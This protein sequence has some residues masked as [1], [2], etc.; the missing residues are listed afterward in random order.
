MKRSA[1]DFY[2]AAPKKEVGE[3]ASIGDKA[4]A[5]E[6][7]L[8]P[9]D[10][11]WCPISR[12]FHHCDDVLAAHIVP[13]RVGPS[14]LGYIFEPS[15][16]ARLNEA[17]NC[18]LIHKS[19]ERAFG[20]GLIVIM[21]VDR[22]ESPLRRWK[23]VLVD[24]SAKNQPLDLGAGWAQRKGNVLSANDVVLKKMSDVDGLELK[25]R[26]DKRPAAR[27]LYFHFVMTLLLMAE[28]KRRG[29]N[30]VVSKIRT[31]NPWPT[32]GRYL[33]RSMLMKLAHQAGDVDDDVLQVIYA[34]TYTSPVSLDDREESECVRRLRRIYR[35]A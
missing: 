6:E 4:Q 8:I 14:L 35:E 15:Y 27:F 30:D 13:Y 28:L 31:G 21:P 3:E 2:S 17:C 1:T 16:G 10:Y 25:F 34:S 19:F 24:N 26:S 23:T 29:Y 32:L 20:K 5:A 22:T 18:L 7:K 33:R 12:D 9:N 11:V